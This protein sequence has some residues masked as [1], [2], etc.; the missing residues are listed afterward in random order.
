MPG[1][2]GILTIIDD[3][4]IL[5]ASTKGF[6]DLCGFETDRIHTQNWWAD[7]T[8]SESREPE[9][10]AL[11]DLIDSQRLQFYEK[12]LIRADGS[13]VQ[14]RVLA[15]RCQ[16]VFL[17]ELSPVGRPRRSYDDESPIY[18]IGEAVSIE[19]PIVVTDKD[20]L[21]R[22]ANG[23]ALSIFGSMPEDELLGKPAVCFFE[24]D[25][26]AEFRRRIE[27]EKKGYPTDVVLKL[28]RPDGI[29]LDL[30][31]RSIPLFG[32]GS[33]AGTICFFRP[34]EKEEKPVPSG[35]ATIGAKLWLSP[36]LVLDNL[37]A[38]LCS[39]KPDGTVRYVNAYGRSFLSIGEDEIAKGMFI[40]ERLREGVV[41]RFR[42]ILDEVLRGAEVRPQ[43]IDVE[44]PEGEFRPAIWCLGWDQSRD[45]VLALAIDATDT[46]ASTLVPDEEFYML[47]SLTARE[48]EVADLLLLGYE[49]KEIGG[50]MG[51]ALP[52]VRSHTQ[53][54]YAKTGVHSKAEL[55]ELARRWRLERGEGDGIA[56]IARILHSR[57]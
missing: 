30:G 53:G 15:R 36:L 20:D 10:Q 3:L 41:G 17:L 42:S 32:R 52:T 55:A 24:P 8:P 44:T 25:C 49:Y 56:S 27:A 45:G 33:F 38:A 18:S 43:I 6:C 23:R 9:I 46:F 26:H 13:R 7:L 51:I 1:T 12:S 29:G 16:T 22:F 19:R 28:I 14:V 37:P 47:Y 35:T 54:I 31:I 57:G 34:L 2:E 40:F 39:L 48:R 4:G 21:I 11:A 50:R 5:I